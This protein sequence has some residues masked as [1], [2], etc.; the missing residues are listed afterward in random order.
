MDIKT[1]LAL[2]IKFIIPFSFMK[3]GKYKLLRKTRKR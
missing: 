3:V 2:G 1:E